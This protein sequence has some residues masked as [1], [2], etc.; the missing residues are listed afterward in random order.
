MRLFSFSGAPLVVVAVVTASLLA[1]GFA[2]DAWAKK[3]RKGGKDR[4]DKVEAVS[5]RTDDDDDDSR[6]DSATDSTT[7]SATPQPPQSS[8]PIRMQWIG[9]LS[10]WGRCPGGSW[11]LSPNSRQTI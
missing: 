5:D 3:G 1:S 4:R 7:G 11:I 8:I 2:Q 9:R 10:R 6:T